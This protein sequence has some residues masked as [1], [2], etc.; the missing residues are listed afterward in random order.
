MMQIKNEAMLITYAD[1][2]GTNLQE[3]NEVLDK[4]LKGVVG[5]IHLLPFYP[6]SGDRGFAPM[7]YTKVE[8]T[9]GDWPEVE[10]MSRDFYMMYDFMINHISRQSP[11]LQ[12]FL[13]KKDESEYAD[14]FIRYKNFW[15]G[16]EPSAEDVDLIYKRKPR[17]PYTEVTFK[18]GTSEKLWCTFDEQQIDL[19]VT[20]E[21]TKKFI[22]D[23]LLFL[24]EKGASI[25]RLDAFAY[26]N[27]KIGSNCFF[28]EPD[29]W[30]ML[31]YSEEIVKPFGVTVLPEIHEHFSIQLK[32]SE[33]DYYV[34]DFALPML[35]LHALYSGEV[36]RL[37]HWL[38]ICPRKQFTTLDTHD[39]IGVVDVKDL[40]S[41]EEAEMTRESLYSQGANVKKIYSTEVYNNLD[42]YQIN[43]TYYSALGNEDQAY[44][45]ARAIQ[46]FAPGIPQIY[47]VGLLA[48]ENDIELLELTKE[49]RNINRHYYTRHEI[50]AEVERPVVQQLFELLKFRNSCPAFNGGIEVEQVNANELK[51]TWSHGQSMARLDGNLL[52]KEFVIL[53]QSE[54]AYWQEVS[55]IPMLNN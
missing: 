21:T 18:D 17:A 34:Y 36:H 37:A 16:G 38:E 25:I 39:G 8:S 29:I 20:T 52:T 5:G 3:L 55:L 32:I 49:G 11:Y 31:K 2:L 41:D 19:D 12:D 42:I 50:D 6:S 44:L 54:G 13:E 24:A 10:A 27:K 33:K 43:C 1:S 53:E 23:N 40:L 22:R 28:V 47:Y 51:I 4:H 45:L 14:L 26:A 30:D 15:P 35:V 46:C 48:G 7:D 9:F